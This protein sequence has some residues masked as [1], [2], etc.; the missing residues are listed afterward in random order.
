MNYYCQLLVINQHG[1]IM[2]KDK[3]NRLY[4]SD[5]QSQ[6]ERL[7]NQVQKRLEDIAKAF[8]D[9]L[10]VPEKHISIE[11]RLTVLTNIENKIKKKYNSQEQGTLFKL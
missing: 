11:I 9:L 2:S 10:T 4:A 1:Y 3:L 8:P 7:N 6:F 5:Y